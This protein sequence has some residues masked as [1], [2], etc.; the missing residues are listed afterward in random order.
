MRHIWMRFALGIVLIGCGAGCNSAPAPPAPEA[1]RR[2]DAAQPAFLS[3]V[4]GPPQGWTGPAFK[5]SAAYP[6]T[7]PP[8]CPKDVCTWL[9]LGGPAQ[10]DGDFSTPP[11]AW[12]TGVWRE[13]SQRVLSYVKE[14]QDPQ[15]ANDVG[16][17]SEVGGKTRWFHVP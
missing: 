17:K 7:P 14:G 13:Y 3:A 5:L 16:F 11:P 4:K 12:N 6:E 8:P 10:F 2:S 15:L 1:S 9:A